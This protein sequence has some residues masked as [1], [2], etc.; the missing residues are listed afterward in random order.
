[1]LEEEYAGMVSAE[2]QAGYNLTLEFDVDNLPD[3]PDNM[4][5]KISQLK[6]NLMGAPLNQYVCRAQHGVDIRCSTF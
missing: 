2:P 1:M 3:S 5:K 6:R 4:I